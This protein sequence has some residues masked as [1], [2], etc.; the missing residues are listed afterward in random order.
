MVKIGKDKF[1][2]ETH[3][4]SLLK[5]ITFRM[6]VLISD[7]S[8][9]SV[10]T[11]QIT[12]TLSIVLLTNLFSTILYYLH[13][14]VWTE[15]TWLVVKFNHRELRS[16]QLTK[17][18]IKAISFRIVVICSDLIVTSE[19]TGSVS[20]ALGIIIFTNVGSTIVYYLHEVLWNFV[21][22]GKELHKA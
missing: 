9:I 19:I 1:V 6:M 20:S 22:W 11:G 12:E 10:I 17:S 21:L 15:W 13:E 4:R 3:K 5:S 7:A 14:R 8:I 2:Y 16:P 18:I